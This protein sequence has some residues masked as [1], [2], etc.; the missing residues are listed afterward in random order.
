M[1]ITRRI[2]AAPPMRDIANDEIAPRNR[3]F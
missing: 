1:R 3:V 2:M